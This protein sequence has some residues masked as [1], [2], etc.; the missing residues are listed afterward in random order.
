MLTGFYFAIAATGRP[1]CITLSAACGAVGTSTE[2]AVG[3]LQPTG[4]AWMH[5]ATGCHFGAV[6][7]LTGLQKGRRAARA[8][9]PEAEATRFLAEEIRS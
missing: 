2:C 9:V 4:G 1:S 6:E 8:Y 7:V 3:S 5:F